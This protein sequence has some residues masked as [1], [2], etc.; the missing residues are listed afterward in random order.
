[1]YAFCL[2]VF[3]TVLSGRAEIPELSWGKD[4]DKCVA[5]EYSCGIFWTNE[6]A[7]LIVGNE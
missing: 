7:E 6:W 4:G 5:N 1:M 2:C 3:I